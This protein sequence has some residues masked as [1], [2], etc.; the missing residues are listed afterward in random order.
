[1]PA[2]PQTYLVF[3][4]AP[5]SREAL[6]YLLRRSFHASSDPAMSVTFDDYAADFFGTGAF[7]L[8]ATSNSDNEAATFQA[9]ANATM[10][11]RAGQPTS[12]QKLV[13]VDVIGGRGF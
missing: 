13:G 6:Q 9:I 11:G 12:I 4:P 7:V 8:R 2:V 1:M 10:H 3:F 5:P